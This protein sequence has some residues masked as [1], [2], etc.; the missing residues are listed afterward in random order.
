VAALLGAL[1]TPQ[2]PGVPGIT[3]GALLW[4][5]LAYTRLR[6]PASPLWPGAVGLACLAGAGYALRI[7]QGKFHALGQRDL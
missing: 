2:P 6:D 5:W 1:A 4:V 7:G 3:V